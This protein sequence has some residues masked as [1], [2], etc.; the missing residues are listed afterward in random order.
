MEQIT[1]AFLLDNPELVLP[2]APWC[3]VLDNLELVTCMLA[4]PWV[5][6]KGV[7][8][9]E[10]ERQLQALAAELPLGRIYFQR[11]N[12]ATKALAACGLLGV[13]GSGRTRR[14]VLRPRGFAGLILN[15]RYLHSDPTMDGSEMEIKRSLVGM[16]NLLV[17]RWLEVPREVPPEEGEVGFLSEA[18]AL[19]LWGQSVLPEARVRRAMDVRELIALQRQKVSSLRSETREALRPATASSQ[20]LRGLDV[21][22]SHGTGRELIPVLVRRTLPALSL[23]ARLLRYEAYLG[24]LDSLDALYG[25]ELRVAD[26]A[27]FRQR[28]RQGSGA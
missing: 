19:G 8:R 20:M 25:A 11:V 12:R 26:F 10:L 1:T 13:V 6:G 5:A 2:V 3:R 14:F 24:Y 17:E 4:Q 15:L 9:A 21:T 7:K 27:M 18:E 28:F 22:G 16:W 23:R